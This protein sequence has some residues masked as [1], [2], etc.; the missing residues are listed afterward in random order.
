MAT[1]K[2]KKQVEAKP[3][4]PADPILI[5]LKGVTAKL[6]NDLDR[7][8]NGHMIMTMNHAEVTADGKA[9]GAIRSG[10][11][12]PCLEVIIYR[13]GN[14]QSKGGRSWLI[15]SEQLFEAVLAADTEREKAPR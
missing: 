10:A 8:S 12:S 4:M 6:L 11:M 15:D 14:A 9:L 5:N 2:T 1:Q 13:D 7:Y 3:Q